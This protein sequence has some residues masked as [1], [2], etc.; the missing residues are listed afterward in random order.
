MFK[1]FLH[2]GFDF[3]HTRI[4]F[5]IILRNEPQRDAGSKIYSHLFCMLGGKEF[6]YV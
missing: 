3:P 1:A 4:S 6:S 2:G 5:L